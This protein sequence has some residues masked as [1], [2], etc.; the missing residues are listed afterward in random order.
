MQPKWY[1]FVTKQIWLWETKHQQ[2]LS[3]S[4]T[5]FV[6]STGSTCMIAHTISVSLQQK[7]MGWLYVGYGAPRSDFRRLR[8]VSVSEALVETNLMV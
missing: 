1:S 7:I 8:Q 5:V 4:G 3:P 6:L 2:A